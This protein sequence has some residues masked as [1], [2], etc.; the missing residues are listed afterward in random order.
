MKCLFCI[1]N[2]KELGLIDSLAAQMSSRFDS[3]V[4]HSAAEADI[5]TLKCET[6]QLPDTD[7]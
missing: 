5:K 7:K 1:A 6:F 2:Y 4:Q 3:S